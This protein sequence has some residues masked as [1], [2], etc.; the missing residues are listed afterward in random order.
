[1]LLLSNIFIIN[2]INTKFSFILS[3]SI[4]Y[5]IL[6]VASY[7]QNFMKQMIVT[8]SIFLLL[9]FV[10]FGY[11]KS[12]V[13]GANFYNYLINPLPM[14]LEG[15]SNFYGYLQNYSRKSYL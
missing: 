11:W 1:M 14:H 6:I 9:F 7:K 3:G 12:I 2:S 13:W 8:N 15:V 5:L 10:C 4:I